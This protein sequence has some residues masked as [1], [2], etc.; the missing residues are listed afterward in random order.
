MRGKTLFAAVT[1]AT[2]AA[3][4][5]VA[6]PQTLVSCP[7]GGQTTSDPTSHGF[8]V[9]NYAADNLATVTLTY[10]ATTVGTYIITLRA[11]TDAFDGQLVATRTKELDVTSANVPNAVTFDFEGAPVAH[12]QTL[13]FSQSV[14]GPAEDALTFDTGTT[15]CTAT[16]TKDFTPPT[17]SVTRNSVGVTITAAPAGACIP[18]GT[19]LCVSDVQGDNRF[20]IIATYKTAQSGGLSGSANTVDLTNIGVTTGGI[21]WFF[22]KS[23]PEML[24]KV[25]NGCAVNN[26]YWVFYSADTNVGFTVTATDTVSG[27]TRTYTNPD[28]TAASPIQDTGAFPCS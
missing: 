6:Q 11:V 3:V 27:H 22:A 15:P 14:L 19:T 5:A 16:E 23:N 17:S 18:A 13:V 12:G 1:M 10:Y 25:L 26:F 8:Y 28:V 21:L 7:N 2:F 20:Q 24:V 4:A 9:E